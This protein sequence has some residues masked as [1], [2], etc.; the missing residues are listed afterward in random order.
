MMQ[1]SSISFNY[2]FGF[3]IFQIMVINVWSLHIWRHLIQALSLDALL[4]GEHTLILS[5][6][7]AWNIFQ[8][9]QLI[10]L[11]ED[12]LLL[13]V[14]HLTAW[15]RILLWFDLYTVK[16]VII[17]RNIF[18]IHFSFCKCVLDCYLVEN[19]LIVVWVVVEMG[20]IHDH[21]AGTW[22]KFLVLTI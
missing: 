1:R 10:K 22:M 17:L 7:L 21:A 4:T 16:L 8:I 9:I 19:Y 6:L 5:L 13:S 14:T 18:E 20:L 3:R 11:I 12:F 15:N 2:I